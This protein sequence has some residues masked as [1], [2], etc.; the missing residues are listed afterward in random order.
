MKRFEGKVALVTGGNSGIGLATARALAAE[1]AQVVIAGRDEGTLGRAAAEIGALAVR[2]DVARPE[3]VDRVIDAARER[4]G[5]L[6]VVFANAGI[7][8]FAPAER[9]T[10]AVYDEVM[11][12][13]VK[14]VYFTIQK[15]LPLLGPGSAIV[16]NASVVAS[17]GVP[18]GSVYAASKAAVRSLGKTFA[19]ELAG[20]GVRVNVVSPGPIE[21]PIYDPTPGLKE[22]LTASVPMQ[23]SGTAEEV[24]STVL[25]LASS[26]ASYI[27]GAEVAVDGGA[28]S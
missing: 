28:L 5:R 24:A 22:R 7:A 6:D 20:R 9:V 27:T 26:E 12:T 11:A 10:E 4:F 18:N 16:I 19:A 14:G 23:R 3:E 1:G 21:T 8:R 2:A 25:F 17:K 15:S 13:N